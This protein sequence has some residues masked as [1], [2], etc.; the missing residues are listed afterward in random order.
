LLPLADA[1][2]KL[3][4]AARTSGGFLL[5]RFRAG[6]RSDERLPDRQKAEQEAPRRTMGIVWLVWA[7][8]RFGEVD[9]RRRIPTAVFLCV[10]ARV[11]FKL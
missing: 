9:R 4:T 1:Q 2:I 5:S 7:C 3:T 10:F 8:L 6:K 11:E